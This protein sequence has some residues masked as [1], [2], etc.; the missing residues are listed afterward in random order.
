MERKQKPKK[1]TGNPEERPSK[2]AIK[3]D[4]KR[5]V[6]TNG[7]VLDAAKALLHHMTRDALHELPKVYEKDFPEDYLKLAEYNIVSSILHVIPKE[8]LD[9]SNKTIGEDKAVPIDELITAFL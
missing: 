3:R 4:G 9:R 8:V 6:L 7:E 1:K 2:Y 5:I